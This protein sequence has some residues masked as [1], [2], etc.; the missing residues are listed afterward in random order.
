MSTSM[1]ERHTGDFPL[2][3]PWWMRLARHAPRDEVGIC[4]PAWQSQAFIGRTLDFALGQTHGRVRVLVSID[5]CDDDTSAICLARAQRDP[6]VAVFVQPTRLGWAGNVNFLLD[7]VSTPYFFL[8]FHDDVIVP[9]YTARLLHALQR[10]PDAASAHCDMDH[11]GAPRPVSVGFAYEGTAAR[12]LGAF[13]VAPE[14]GSPLRSLTRSALLAD[15]LRLPTGEIDGLWA[16]EPYLMQLVAAGAAVHVPEILYYRWNQREGGL[17]DGWKRLA[18]AEVHAG[19]AGN[20]RTALE[21]IDR[22]TADASERRAL[23]FCLYVHMMPR[24]RAIERESQGAIAIDPET[25]S[26]RFAA[27]GEPC[28]LA[29]LG[30]EISSWA[31]QRH[32]RLRELERRR[33]ATPA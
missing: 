30:E 17:T 2:R 16:N 23:A 8:Y 26:A 18:P 5:Q 10:R 11:F 31:L 7:Q 33:Q 22:A 4:I 15:G 1:I 12:R 6:R 3:K 14:R 19:H 9:Q 21:I 29:C 28:D 20:I 13:L 32:A 24:L 25:V 27:A